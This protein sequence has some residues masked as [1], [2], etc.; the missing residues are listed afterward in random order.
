LLLQV[1][2]VGALAAPDKQTIK[3]P[4]VLVAVPQAKQVL[5]LHSQMLVVLAAAKPQAE[6]VAQH[7]AADKL[8]LLEQSVK[9]ETAVFMPLHLAAA[10]AAVISAAAAAAQITVVQAQM[11]AAAAAADQVFTQLVVLVHKV[12]KLVM[13]KL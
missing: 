1:E 13:A 3:L 9:A 8:V 2:V 11:A 4:V 5:A 12:S 7:G 10:A 6:T